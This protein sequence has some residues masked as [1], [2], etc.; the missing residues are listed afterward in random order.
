[1]EQVV[2]SWPKDTLALLL[3]GNFGDAE[4]Q[5]L[6][7]K[8]KEK[9]SCCVLLGPLEPGWIRV[10]GDGGLMMKWHDVGIASSK[11]KHSSLFS[12]VR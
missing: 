1:M 4:F 7:A 5:P 6:D 12:F 2:E 8:A 9:L 10:A 11:K 3:F